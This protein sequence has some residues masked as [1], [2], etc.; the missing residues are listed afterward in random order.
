MN[1]IKKL[2]LFFILFSVFIS[3]Y[4]PSVELANTKK[5]NTDKKVEDAGSVDLLDYNIPINEFVYLFFDKSFFVK[6]NENKSSTP[7]KKIEIGNPDDYKAVVDW[8]VEGNKR[9]IRLKNIKTGKEYIV[10]EGNTKG[11]VILLERNLFFYKF[12]IGNTIIKVKR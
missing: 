1:N 9:Y 5:D 4:N 8:L 3:C 6:I 10:K 7:T 2:L 11:E 12:K